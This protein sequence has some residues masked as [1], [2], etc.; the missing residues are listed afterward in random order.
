MM[1]KQAWICTSLVSAL[2]FICTTSQTN[3]C[4][5]KVQPLRK[6]S[7]SLRMQREPVFGCLR[8]A[9]EPYWH[10]DAEWSDNCTSQSLHVSAALNVAQ[11]P[12][13]C[14]WATVP[15]GGGVALQHW[16]FNSVATFPKMLEREES[17][18]VTEGM[19]VKCKIM[20]VFVA[21]RQHRGSKFINSGKG[22]VHWPPTSI[23]SSIS[24]LNRATE[25]WRLPNRSCSL[26][27]PLLWMWLSFS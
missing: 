9:C 24:K 27:K 8:G 22:N 5:A 12:L 19:T 15:I 21:T 6:V 2:W 17:C 25:T 10:F 13:V 7:L 16:T 14:I 23:G 20:P 18:K 1:Q 3:K 26:L 11:R 4:T